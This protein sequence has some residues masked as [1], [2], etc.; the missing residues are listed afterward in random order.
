MEIEK[1]SPREEEEEEV[2]TSTIKLSNHLTGNSV[3]KDDEKNI[4]SLL[5]V[6]TKIDQEDL[7]DEEGEEHDEQG[8]KESLPSHV[9][10]SMPKVEII[11]KRSIPSEDQSIPVLEEPSEQ[12]G[13]KFPLP[14]FMV[15][16]L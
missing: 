9:D 14:N 11:A 2:S 13:E 10:S 6:D 7:G 8:N 1:E 5:G 4:G 15:V 3:G 16:I 12:T